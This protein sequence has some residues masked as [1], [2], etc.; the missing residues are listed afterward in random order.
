[1]RRP[2]KLVLP[3]TALLAAC[4]AEPIGGPLKLEV[5]AT[6]PVSAL[7]TVNTNGQRCWIKSGDR[8][9]RDYQLV[10]EL[11]T[12]TG[13]PR[14]LLLRSG[15]ATGLPSLVI[16]GEDNPVAIITYG[17]LTSD[18]LSNRINSD[19]QRWSAGDNRCSAK[20]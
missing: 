9:F 10:P 3:I 2:G 16:E 6:G 13:K 7:Q 11:D 18:P 8:A 5:G 12:R 15:R 14:L 4:Q 17:K 20:A 1:M 19:I